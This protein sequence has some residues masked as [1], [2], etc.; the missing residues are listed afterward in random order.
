MDI[1]RLT[2]PIK[3]AKVYNF[4]EKSIET[5]KV[6]WPVALLLEK[7]NEKFIRWIPSMNLGPRYDDQIE[8]ITNRIKWSPFSH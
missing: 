7:Y 8:D 3:D 5:M 2:T 4:Q 1:K 6:P